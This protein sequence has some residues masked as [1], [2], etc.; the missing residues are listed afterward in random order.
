MKVSAKDI[1]KE[2]GTSTASVSRAFRPD[3]PM[4]A[5]LREKILL[6]AREFG[7][8]PPSDRGIKSNG[9]LMVSLVV[10]DILNPYYASVLDEFAKTA[11]CE[12]IEL[13]F[14]VVPSNMTV[15]ATMNQVLSARTD[16]V[17]VT[18]TVLNS[19]IAKQCQ[20]RG[21]PVV[22]FGRVQVDSRLTAITGDNYNGARLIAQRFVS[23]GRKKI[24]FLG[25]LKKASTHLE[26]RRGFLDSLEEAGLALHTEYSA[27]FNY[28]KAHEIALDLLQAKDRPDALFCANDIMAFGVIDALRNSSISLPDDLAVIGYDDVPMSAWPSYQLTTMRQRVRLMVRETLTTVSALIDEPGLQGTIKITPGYLV[29]RAS[30]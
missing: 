4:S 11:L 10:G 9:N 27:A 6:K 19:E 15:D 8:V 26:R 2:L 18:S 24:A 12:N 25:G 17:I 22:L 5:K 29:E 21:L 7:Y 20:K 28:Q 16:G 30:G 1:A 23:N 13:S 3:K 14:H